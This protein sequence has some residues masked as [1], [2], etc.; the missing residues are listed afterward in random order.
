MR[1]NPKPFYLGRIFGITLRAHYSWL[2]VFPIYSYAISSV[3]LPQTVP[4]L[5]VWEY[6]T[7]GI[8]T[9]SLLFLSVL[10]HELAHSVMARMEGIGT[11][12]ITLYMFGGLASLGGQPARP[13]AEFKIAIAGPAAS[14]MIG[15]T[16]FAVDQILFRHTRQLAASQVFRHLGIV[17]WLL[18]AFNILPGLPL[19]GGRVLRAVLWHFNKNF[20]EA[21][22]LALRAG[23][24]ISLALIV[25]G[26]Y[27]LFKDVVTG[28]WSL[29]IGLL[30][31]IMLTSSVRR[32]PGGV[33]PL[34]G[35][36]GAVMTRDVVIISPDMQVQDFIDG[37]LKNNRF[38]SF[39][40]A[41][42][43]R[44]HGL[45]LL[46]QLKRVAPEEWQKLS[47]RDVMQPVDDSMFINWRTPVAQARSILSGNGIGRAAVLDS[48]GLLIGY[49]SLRD[50]K[51]DGKDSSKDGDGSSA[52]GGRT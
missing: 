20:R 7:L 34:A 35:T 51:D 2:P 23:I 13:S 19:D 6:W 36:V 5:P 32:G 14:F 46:E 26:A 37:V 16:F 29:T 31:A 43:G 47:V 4:G 52:N 50:I 25:T 17:N 30:L 44:L 33:R 49:V 10:A 11:G 24:T 40:V 45:L 8:V 3:L 27:L 38:T 22:R 48:A 28:L 15:T 21:T 12:D 1:F 39:P 18:A 9:T 42:E 41:V